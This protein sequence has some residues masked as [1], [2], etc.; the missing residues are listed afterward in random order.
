MQIDAPINRG[1]SGGPSF[2]LNGRVVG[3]N[4]AIY[5]PTGGSVGIGFDIPA[6]VAASVSRQLIADGKVVRGYIGASV[7]PVTPEIAESL[8]IGKPTGALV[9]ELTPGAPAERAGLKTGDLILKID[10][11]AV[12]SASDLTR[13]VG[14]VK[15]GADIK[16]DVRR[17]GR[18]QSIVL[19]S[20]LRPA[21][22]TLSRPG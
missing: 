20:G 21:E 2:D 19:R 18:E 3:V 16:L 17:Q 8:G 22:D 10:G 15:P 9:A 11:Q 4:S 6:D 13:R 5:S 14:L 1:N 12:N 7:Q